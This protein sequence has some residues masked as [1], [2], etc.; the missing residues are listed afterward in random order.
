MQHRQGVF[1]LH[2]QGTA[3]IVD[4]L[5][6]LVVLGDSLAVLGLSLCPFLGTICLV[7]L[8]DEST[9]VLSLHASHCSEEEDGEQDALQG[10]IRHT[11]ILDAGAGTSQSLAEELDVAQEWVLDLQD[12]NL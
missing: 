4:G 5:R 11:T 12:T 9:V 1:L 7:A 6:V 8:S 3:E 2:H 10:S